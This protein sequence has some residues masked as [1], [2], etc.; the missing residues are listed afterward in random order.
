MLRGWKKIGLVEGQKILS[1]NDPLVQFK[2]GSYLRVGPRQLR[3]I[4]F[5]LDSKL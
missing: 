2:Q 1:I 5:P 4:S 3:S